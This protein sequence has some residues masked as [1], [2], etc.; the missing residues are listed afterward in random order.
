MPPSEGMKRGVG[1]ALPATK[2]AAIILSLASGASIQEASVMHEISRSTITSLMQND[3]EFKDMLLEATDIAV[4][5]VLAEVQTNVRAQVKS[6]GPKALEV[7]T[8]AL[9][10][11]D[12]RVALQAA[13]IVLRGTGIMDGG[14]LD[15]RVGL[16]SAVAGPVQF[17]D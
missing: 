8:K 2:K 11:D 6:L 5:T 10:S 7:L 13:G 9:D 12:G 4:N 14:K 15:I 16:E 1:N 17:T 3:P